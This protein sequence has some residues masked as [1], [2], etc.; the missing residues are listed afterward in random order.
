MYYFLND[1]LQFSKSGIE[2]AELKRLELFKQHQIPAKIV[3][4]IFA[5]NLHAVMADAGLADTDLVNLFDFFCG[6]QQV[7]SQSVKLADFKIPADAI[8]TR[9][10]RQVHVVRQGKLM[11]IIYLR[12]TEDEISNVQYFDINGKTLKMTWWDTRGMK[13]LEQLFDWDGKIVQEAYFGPDEQIHL[14]KLHFL[15]HAGQERITW[16]VLNY[17]G[18][19]WTF[20][21]LNDLT[22]FFYDE[23]NQNDEENVFICDRTVE[24][25]WGLFNMVTPAKKILH[26]H[27]NHVGEEADSL[28][29]SFNNNYAHALNNWAN[30]DAVISATPEQSADVIARFGQSIPAFTIPVG[31]VEETTLNAPQVPFEQRQKYL[32]V[33]VARLSPEKQQNHSIEAFQQ[34]YAQF[35]EAR[36]EFWG[37]ANGDT[38]QQLKA[39][40]KA[41]NL[42]KVIQFKG[43]TNDVN[44]VYNHAQVG[45]LPSRAEGFSLMLLEA[46]AHGLPMIAN[47]VKYGPSDIIQDGVSGVLTTAGNVQQL[48][49]AMLDLLS[50]QDK[51]ATYSTNAYQNSQR[52]SAAAVF[53]K[54]QTLLEAF[55]SGAKP[56]AATV[57]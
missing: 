29:A 26:L 11:M 6:S 12:P 52:Y 7:S 28:H 20:N 24:C 10:D 55:P 39:Q 4:R 49:D 53:D 51:L 2:H 32:M 1:N 19:S 27:N 15:N 57:K 42:E 36:L 5:M 37:Y 56:V 48:A 43:Y 45:L 46:Q 54:W 33:Q 25:A 17:H 35:P 23:L 13:C 3:T 16:R 47:D 31:Y 50:H 18:T 38:E 21:G 40:V 9:K 30:W 22:R 44:A 14:E 34:V 41:A 8:K